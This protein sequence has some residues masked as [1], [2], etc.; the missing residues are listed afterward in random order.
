VTLSVSVLGHDMTLHFPYPHLKVLTVDNIVPIVRGGADRNDNLVTC[1]F[2]RNNRK[3]N[4]DVAELLRDL[5]LNGEPGRGAD[6]R[7]LRWFV[8]R[9]R[10]IREA[11]A[12]ERWGG[13]SFGG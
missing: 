3:R 2:E 4:R 10:L 13:F 11:I 12:S 6:D 1:C 7:R 5:Y 9:A 8:V